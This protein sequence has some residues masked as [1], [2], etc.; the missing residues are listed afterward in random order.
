[1]EVHKTIDELQEEI[2]NLRWQLAEAN[3]T[4]D[5]IRCGEIDA[6]IVK[7]K[8]GHQL[9][10][11]KSADQTYRVFIEKMK[12]G[13]VT[14]SPQGFIIYSNSSFAS[15]LNLPLSKVLGQPFDKF[16]SEQQKT[17][18]ALM[19]EQGWKAEA[20]GE[21]SICTEKKEL[22]P[23]LISLTT[24]ELDEGTALS[25]IVTDLSMQKQTEKLLKNKNKELVETH[26][27]LAELNHELE[28]RVAERT[29]EL[30][31]SREHFKFLADTIPIMVW[32]ALPDGSVDYVNKRWLDYT[33]RSV[34]TMR[35]RGFEEI[36]HPDDLQA[37]VNAWDNALKTGE[38]YLHEFR[39]LRASDGIYRWHTGKAVPFKN[40]QNKIV[41]WF[42][43]CTDTEEQK[44]AMNNKDEFISMASHELKTPV[45]I[46]KAFSHVLHSTFEKDSNIQAVAYVERM[47]KQINR[48]NDLIADLL[49]ASKFNAGMML[50]ESMAFDFNGLLSEI[51]DQMQFTTETHTIQLESS[52]S[53]I[54]N[55]D[56]NRLGQVI[57]NLISNAI[58]YSPKGNK[59]IVRSALVGKLIELSVQDFGI[60]I[61]EDQ[62]SKLFSRFFRA[63]E[64]KSNTFPGLGL[65]LY[66]SN[67]IIK[68]H[69]GSLRFKSTEGKGSTFYVDL[70]ASS[71]PEQ[72]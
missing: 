10:T 56:R 51:T 39:I 28:F 17:V 63:S 3:D 6:L 46:I 53:I 11:L 61:P 23:V 41:A 25:I 57:S 21:I 32:T 7:D 1:M 13:A 14:L 54:M 68:R 62:Q 40:E 29:H 69:S 2:S 16:V 5:A 67:E 22:L 50:F 9:Y 47:D 66:I 19:M 45:T 18:F 52:G 71:Y 49:D 31:L 20:K 48:L 37:M 72:R 58:K 70:P 64:V 26:M 34:E 36:I 24:L 65:G 30:S 15:M 43:I 12:E 60:G 38:N 8:S 59:I 35:N 55:G 27:A 33:E 42:G 44:I 4:I